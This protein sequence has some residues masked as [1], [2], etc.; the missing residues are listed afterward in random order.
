MLVGGRVIGPK[1][2]NARRRTKSDLTTG[3]PD[4]SR[5]SAGNFLIPSP[6]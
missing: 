5:I 1:A 2:L 6:K 4:T 3:N